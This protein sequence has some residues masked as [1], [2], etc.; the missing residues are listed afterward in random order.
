MENVLISFYELN[1]KDQQDLHL[2]RMMEIAG[3]ARKR[4]REETI[5]E[6]RKPK[7]KTVNY[8]LLIDR[9]RVPV[10]KTAFVNAHNITSKR[11]RRIANLLEQDIA[12]HDSRGKT[13]SANTIS[14]EVCSKIHDHIESFPQKESHYTTHI[15]KYLSGELTVKKMYELFLNAY[16]DLEGVVKYSFYRL[17]FKRNF[18]LSFGRPVKDTCSECEALGNKINSDTLNDTAKRVASAELLVHKH[19]SK[20]FYTSMKNSTTLAKNDAKILTLCF[21][22]M[23]VLDLPKI[24]VQEVYYF[25]QLSVNTFGIYNTKTDKVTTYVYHEGIARK[26]PDDV[27]S[28]ILHY[29][30]N[31]VDAEV[32]EL[33]LYCDNCWGQNK[34]HAIVRMM[35]C[36]TELKIFEKI[37]L[38]YPIR[39]HSFLPCDRA[40]GLIKRKL[41]Q[42]DRLYTVDEYIEKII[43]ASSNIEN[44]FTVFFVDSSVILD[45][46]NWFPAF[47]YRNKKSEPG[48]GPITNFTLSRYHYFEFKSNTPHVIQ[49]KQ[50]IGGLTKDY[51]RLRKGNRAPITLPT[52]ILYRNKIPMLEAK[53]TDLKKLSPYIPNNCKTF[54]D[55]IFGWPTENRAERNNRTNQH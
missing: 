18:D 35:M 32:K 7:S 36:L 38:H 13:P 3:V 22:F 20:K 21:D 28:F 34:N 1:T 8:F 10:C 17:Y 26:S 41:R 25:R 12:P 31:F 2:Q 6:N 19:R 52:D 37:K 44:K 45:F 5:Q 39:G 14:Q 16:P 40:F 54:W 51:F 4:G 15:K 48:N 43:L 11:V 30:K 47:Y 9:E 29:L 55:D 23:A 53:I 49:T 50:F 24:P 33:H 42:H 46:Q 27:C